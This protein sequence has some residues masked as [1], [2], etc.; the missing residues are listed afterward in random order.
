VQRDELVQCTV[1]SDGAGLEG[2]TAS[3]NRAPGLVI[4]HER[5]RALGGAV[6]V[7]PA[8]YRGTALTVS[9]PFKEAHP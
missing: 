7:E 1:E 8:K 9:V 2:L 6:R 5:V 4:I 3:D